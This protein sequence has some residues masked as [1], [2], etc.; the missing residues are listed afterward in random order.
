M[1]RRMTWK[2]F[3][4]VLPLLLL[5]IVFSLYPILSS[6]VYT[7]FDYQTNNQSKNALYT[8]ATLN[9]ALYAEDCDYLVHYLKKDVDAVAEADKPALQ[10]LLDDLSAQKAMLE[11]GEATRALAAGTGEEIAAMLVLAHADG[12]GIDLHQF[13]Q[14]IL[15]TA[16]DADRAAQRYVELRKLFRRQFACGIYRRARFAHKHASITGRLPARLSANMDGGAA[17]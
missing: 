14:R 2:E 7:L 6:F 12:L 13:G 5:V 8:G 1:Q 11:G 4:F 15:H 16:R 3:C 9:A 10:A 17:R